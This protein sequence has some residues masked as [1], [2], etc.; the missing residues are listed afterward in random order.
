MTVDAPK[1]GKTVVALVG[2]DWHPFDRLVRWLDA[3]LEQQ[4]ADTVRCFIQHGSSGRPRVAEGVDYLAADEVPRLL[5]EADV[6]VCHAGPAT[7]MECRRAGLLPIVMPRDDLLGEHVDDH[8]KRF[9]ARLD[10][11]GLVSRVSGQPELEALLSQALRSPEDFSVSAETDTHR[12]EESVRRFADLVAGA[13]TG[14]PARVDRPV[15]L[16]LG[17][18]GRSGSTLVDR[19]LGEVPGVCSVGEIVHLWERGVVYNERCGCGVAFHD[20]PFWSDVG[21]KAFGDWSALDVHEVL[22]LKQSV[23]RNRFIP[24]MLLNRLLPRYR[25]RL[26]AYTAVVGRLYDAIREVS[27]ASVIV[28]SSKHASFGYLLRSASA[29][30]LRLLQIV[31]DP[32]AVAHSWARRRQR[33]EVSDEVSFMP[34]YPPR[35]SALL[36]LAHNT[37]VGALGRLVPSTVVRYEDVVAHPRSELRRMLAVAGVPVPEA[38]IG[39]VGDGEVRFSTTHSVAGNPMRFR[40]GTVPLRQDDEWRGTMSRRVQRMILA[41]TW[42]LAAPYGYRYRRPAAPV[43]RS[44]ATTASGGGASS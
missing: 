36:W 30:D 5:A 31:R 41:M 43:P 11:S 32:R 17:G 27:G 1:R 4:P 14:S 23:D 7:I 13:I 9:A 6:V 20:C 19:L 44:S 34:V 42:P 37:L 22:K 33:P 8:Q 15:V 29:V 18:F 28:D 39:H 38:A 2:T 26:W 40:V 24:S 12:Q 25:R 16:Y 21:R 10:V 3:W 35:R